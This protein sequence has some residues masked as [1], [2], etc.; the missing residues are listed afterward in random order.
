[1]ISNF[2]AVFLN[3]FIGNAVRLCCM[4]GD[5]ETEKNAIR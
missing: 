4:L 5:T 2:I 3:G 1:M